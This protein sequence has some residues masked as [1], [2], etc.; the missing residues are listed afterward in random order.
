M[1]TDGENHEQIPD[2]TLAE[3]PKKNIFLAVVGLG[4][5]NGGLVPKDPDRPYAGYKTNEQGQPVLSKMDSE[6]VKEIAKKAKG[7]AVI[8]D[9]PFPNLSDLLTEI[10]GLNKGN[11]RDLDLD[12]KDAYYHWPLVIGI[13]LWVF[14]TVLPF[15]RKNG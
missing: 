3:L 6:L 7:I 8:S 11:L 4:T 15:R 5:K 10:N 2:K 12:I 13:F 9:N 1:V 14:A